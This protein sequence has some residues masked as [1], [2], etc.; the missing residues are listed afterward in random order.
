MLEN[1]KINYFLVIEVQWIFAKFKIQIN[2]LRNCKIILYNVNIIHFKMK[3]H[4]IE[5]FYMIIYQI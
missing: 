3:M 4:N 1:T 5:N 2:F